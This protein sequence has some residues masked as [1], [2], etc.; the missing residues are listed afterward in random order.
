MDVVQCFSSFTYVSFFLSAGAS[1]V[2]E[3]KKKGV[4]CQYL[5]REVNVPVITVRPKL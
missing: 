1:S 3:E 5:R 4:M 2:R